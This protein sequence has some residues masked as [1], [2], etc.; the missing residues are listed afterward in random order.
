[1]LTLKEYFDLSN[2][3]DNGITVADTVID[4]YFT[5][6]YD[7]RPKKD[8]YYSKWLDL[9]SSLLIIEFI[10]TRD[11]IVTCN[12]HSVVQRYADAFREVMYLP[13]N[14]EQLADEVMEEDM[15]KITAGGLPE[16]SYKTLFDKFTIIMLKSKSQKE[17]K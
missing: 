9:L 5:V 17:D 3:H 1:M 7:K 2:T 14:D 6:A 16:S 8:D 15:D 11:N 4:A 13:D 10:N 12:T